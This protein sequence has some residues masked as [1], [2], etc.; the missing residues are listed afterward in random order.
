MQIVA[1][2]YKN[3][4]FFSGL[5][6]KSF[7][8]KR[9]LGLKYKLKILIKYTIELKDSSIIKPNSIMCLNIFF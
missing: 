7:D 2:Q 1:K 3:N 6:E 9:Y 5:A 8:F 4:S